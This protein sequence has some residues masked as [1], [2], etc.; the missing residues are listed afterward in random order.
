VDNVKQ[1]FKT[2]H[3]YQGQAMT[4]F[5]IC[6]SFFLVPLFLGTSLLAKYIDMKQANVQAARYQAWEYTVWFANDEERDYLPGS[7]GEVMSGFDVF[8]QP[9]KSTSETRKESKQ[10]FYTNPGIDLATTSPITD[11]DKTAGWSKDTAN[12]LWKNH[13][14]DL[15]YAGVNGNLASLASSTDTPTIPIIGDVMN[16]ML[17]TIGLAFDLIGELLGV[18]KSSVGFNAINTHGYAVSS[19]SMQVAV[20]PM[21]QYISGAVSDTPNLIRNSSGGNTLNFTTTASVLSDAWNAGGSQHV[22][23]QA[24]GTVPTTVL[25][26]IFNAI[27]GFDVVWDIITLLAP[28]LTFCDPVVTIPS[29]PLAKEQPHGSLWLGYL[30]VDAV[31][32]DRLIPDPAKPDERN[33]THSCNDAGMCD[34]EPIVARPPV[35]L[36][37]CRG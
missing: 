11:G 26:E 28:E 20:P 32:P 5:L 33:G 35:E 17:D 31:H 18:L 36:R 14:G 12:P 23:N 3:A 1:P 16:I 10:R 24:G 22:Y 37:E 4:E 30:D 2:R 25:N 29:P 27:P 21:Y 34:F 8:D 19:E 13:K 15:L 9:V 7:T 6:A